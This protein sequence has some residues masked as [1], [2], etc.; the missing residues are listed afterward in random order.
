MMYRLGVFK[1]LLF[2]LL[3]FVVGSI[4]SLVTADHFLMA[5]FGGVF[6]PPAIWSIFY[7][8][9]LT[10]LP[11]LLTLGGSLAAVKIMQ[12]RPWKKVALFS[13]AICAI[14]WITHWTVVIWGHYIWGWTW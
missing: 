9:G 14:T 2:F 6:E 8:L 7:E 12:G 10:V 11:V 5:S 3:W 1:G 4:V 13:F